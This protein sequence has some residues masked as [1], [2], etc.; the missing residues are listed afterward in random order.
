MKCEKSKKNQRNRQIARYVSKASADKFSKAGFFTIHSIHLQSV[1]TFPEY[2]FFEFLRHEIQTGTQYIS[3]TLINL[4]L[5]FSANKVKELKDH[6]QALGFITELYCSKHNGSTYKIN[7]DTVIT[8]VN[9]LNACTNRVE[10]LKIAND[11]RISKGLDTIAGN[12]IEKYT[13]SAFDIDSQMSVHNK[14]RYTT[15]EANIKASEPNTEATPETNIKVAN[16]PQKDP[17]PSKPK[18]VIKPFPKELTYYLYKLNQ[19]EAEKRKGNDMYYLQSKEAYLNS[20]KKYSN[21][22]YEPYYDGLFWKTQSIILNNRT[23]SGYNN[24]MLKN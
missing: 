18:K 21:N 5:G 16:V 15:P 10:R 12:R 24:R 8:L 1:L 22:E 2:A 7:T 13:G 17:V 11:F 6:L 14:E 20:L 23:L 19:N 3:Y 4:E 9:K